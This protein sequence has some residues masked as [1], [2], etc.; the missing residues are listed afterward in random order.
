[1]VMKRLYTT[2]LISL[3]LILS[4]GY[5]YASTEIDSIKAYADAEVAIE[6]LRKQKSPDWGKIS[7]QYLE[8]E[9]FV[10]MTDK[11]W[12]TTYI[13]EI[14]EAI[15]R[16]TAGDQVKVNQQTLAKGLQHITVLNMIDA[17]DS[18]S[19]D[20][21]AGKKLST[22][23]EGIRP[24]FIRRDKDF[25]KSKK[26]LEKTADE[27]IIRFL[28]AESADLLTARRALEDAIAKTYALCVLFEIMEVEKLRDSDIPK[29]DVKRMEAVIFYRIIQ[30]RIKKRSPKADEV[31]T[32]LIN[33]SYK[34]MD[35]SVLKKYLETGLKGIKL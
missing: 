30:P 10:K 25:F 24:T 8:T 13:S 5:L 31:I 17:M 6:H 16:C 35:V 34:T 4:S 15:K 18:I 32:N 3:F 27:S 26:T 1:M 7:K 12:G 33:G 2:L 14:N 23:F 21:L 19:K 20:P 29:C 9:S 22:F 28:K 11:K